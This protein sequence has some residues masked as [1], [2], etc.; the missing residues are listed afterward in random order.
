MPLATC[1]VLNS[2]TWCTVYPHGTLFACMVVA[3]FI[4]TVHL[5]TFT[6]PCSSTQF[7]LHLHGALFTCTVPCSPARCPVHL[8]GA[9]F[10]RTVPCTPARCHVR[11]H[12]GLFFY[13]VLCFPARRSAHMPV[14]CSP[15]QCPVPCSPAQ[16]PVYPAQ[17]PVYPCTVPC[18]TLQ[19]PD[20]LQGALFAC[21]VT[22]L[23]AQ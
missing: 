19:C 3:L 10:P 16:F 11:L 4:R 12:S 7:H 14:P 2:P 21:T 17:C 13:P 1:M 23:S 8:H 5:I 15:A 22:C 6:V 18:S 20:C 9:L